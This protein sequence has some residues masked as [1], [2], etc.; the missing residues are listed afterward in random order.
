M[1]SYKKYIQ[2]ENLKNCILN[3][4][5][6]H[7]D[8][9]YIIDLITKKHSFIAGAYYLECRNKKFSKNIQT[10]YDLIKYTISLITELR[11]IEDI[12]NQYL[13]NEI[14]YSNFN[15]EE[16]DNAKICKYC[17]CEFNHPYDNRCIILNEIVDNEKLRNILENNDFNDEDSTLAKNYHNSLD[18]NGC[19][20]I[21]YKQ[22]NDKNSY[23]A[24]SSHLTCL[25]KEIRNSM[26]GNNIKN[27]GIVN[28]HPVI[29]YCLCK[30]NRI[31][32][33]I[34]KNYMENRESI[35]S[36]F[37]E[38]KKFIKELFLTILNGGVKDICSDDKRI[39]NYLKL[40][41]KEIVKIQ[42]YFYSHDKRYLGNDYNYKGKNLSRL[43]LD[44]ENQ[45]LQVMINYFIS[46]NVDILTLEYDGLKI[47]TDKNSRHFSIN[48]LELCI[49]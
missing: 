21:I 38:N 23:Y 47:Y 16:F 1:P 10:F 15:Q 29:L 9:E 34:L 19:K 20:K 30:K 24:D 25:K 46:K 12:E 43:I 17:N 6:I 45:I 28:A 49:Y 14:D 13:Q 40:F 5:I 2:F 32:C 35:L 27:I 42:N 31:D 4:W 18:E 36:S 33:N 11:Y 3:N 41:E 39:N 8:F 44:I 22:T 26:M 48:E 37:G 7:F